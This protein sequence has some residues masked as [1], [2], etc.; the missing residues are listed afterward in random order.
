MIN[1]KN[2]RI[3][4][5]ILLLLTLAILAWAFQLL[6]PLLG[7]LAWG[8]IIAVVLY[9]FYDRLNQTLKKPIFSTIIIVLITSFLVISVVFFITN[10]LIR[11][12][13]HFTSQAQSNNQI[14]P[15]L[16]ESIQKLPL[17][18]EPINNAWVAVSTNFKGTLS[19]HSNEMSNASKHVLTKLVK[20]GRDLFLFLISIIFSGFLLV[21]AQTFVNITRKFANRVAGERGGNILNIIKSTI[22]NVSRGIIGIAVLQTLI[23]GVLLFLVQAPSLGLLCLI[24]LILSIIQVGLI[25]LVIPIIIWLFFAKSLVVATVM[26]VLLVLNGLLDS[27]LKPLVLARGLSTPAMVIF[28]GVIGGVITYGFLGIFIGPVVLAVTYDLIRQW[29]E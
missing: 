10:D 13:S 6:Y 15:N 27:L 5:F 17:I 8:S 11:S 14:L 26:S 22:Q 21:Y 1:T 19:Q 16:P 18:G 29:I 4:Q 24:G 12:V 9:P 7:I 28:M 3:D 23:L 20:A 2:N 25:I